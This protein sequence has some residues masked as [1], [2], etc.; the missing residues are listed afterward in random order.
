M[1]ALVLSTLVLFACSQDDP[2]PPPPPSNMTGMAPVPTPNGNNNG[3]APVPQPVAPNPVAPAT[4][5]V[6]AGG[7]ITLRPGFMPDP[8][9]VNGTSGGPISARNLNPQCT[10]YI[11]QAANHTLTASA[12]FSNLIIAVHGGSNDT[13][14]VVQKPDGTYLCNDDTDGFHPMVSGPIPAGNVNIWVGSYQANQRF[15]YTLG[16]SEL[17]S[18][19]PSTLAGGGT[20]GSTPSAAL[21]TDGTNSNFGT[22]T[23]TPGFTPDPHVVQGTSGGSVDASNVNPQC[24]GWVSPQPD[25]LF[26]TQQAFS[27]L[28]ILVSSTSDTTLV[29]HKPD[30]TYLCNDDADGLNPAVT[31]LFTPG[32]YRIWVGSYQ[33]GQNS[34]Y[35]LGFTELSGITASQLGS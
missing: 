20:T 13:T 27:N 28:K 8:H 35:R 9:R 17:A 22:V 32:T 7:P 18:T 6:A 24:R 14:L 2:A 16:L 21:Q 19:R 23:L 30:G 3:I 29:I 5:Q 26:T 12:P 31:G 1:R 34:A 10:G 15:P 33:Q 4:G 11:S 25:H